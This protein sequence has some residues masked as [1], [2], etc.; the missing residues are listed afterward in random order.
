MDEFWTT[1]FYV[2][3]MVAV[4]VGAY[5]TT[6]F[7]SGKS[8][9]LLKGRYIHVLDRLALGKDKNVVLIE[10]GD[11]TLL[12]GVTNQSINNLG[13]IDG[14]ALKAAKEQ[15]IEKPSKGFA[16]QL[17]DFIINAKDAQNNLRKARMQYK[18][19]SSSSEGDLLSRMDEAVQHRRD[20]MEKGEGEEK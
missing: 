6:K 20:R 11:Q 13:Q 17:K 14:E 2:V 16:Q 10:V 18:G 12:V 5:L 1:F 15:S 8:R 7:I 3:V 9:K 19:Q 4:L